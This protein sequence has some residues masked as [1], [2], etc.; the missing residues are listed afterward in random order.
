V[1][2]PTVPDPT[3]RTAER[4][5]QQTDYLISAATVSSVSISR[6]RIRTLADQP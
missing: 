6:Q 4:A 5:R 2:D 3:V 1:P